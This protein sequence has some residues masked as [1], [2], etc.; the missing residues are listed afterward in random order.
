MK[1]FLIFIIYHCIFLSL[2]ANPD[3]FGVK[4]YY[5]S[6]PVA[7]IIS[8][9]KIETEFVDDTGIKTEVEKGTYLDKKAFNCFKGELND[10]AVLDCTI[11]NNQYLTLLKKNN[12]KNKYIN[13]TMSYVRQVNMT[14]NS[15]PSS[16]STELIPLKVVFAQ[17]FVSETNKDGK[18]IKYLPEY[19]SLLYYP[20]AVNKNKNKTIVL[21]TD[22]YRDEKQNYLPIKALIFVNGYVSPEKPYLYERNARARKIQISYGK[23]M[24]EVELKDIGNYQVIELPESINPKNNKGISITITDWY[25]GTKYD[26]IVIS[27]I[28]FINGFY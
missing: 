19:T 3:Y 16:S 6:E 12:Q 26:D 20:W 4:F 23:T 25:E 27:G 1:K 10:Y 22:F 7:L 21:N 11:N 2:F 18:V 17:S 13:W 9:N 14:Q 28:Y 24:V 15:I 8:Q 5:A